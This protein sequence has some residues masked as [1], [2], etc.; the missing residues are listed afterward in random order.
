MDN[1][2]AV[3]IVVAAIGIGLGVTLWHVSRGREILNLWAQ[4][5][6]YRI[7]SSEIRWFNRG[8]FFWT[9]S[10]GQMVYYVVIQTPDGQT[11]RGYVRCGSFFWGLMKEQVEERWEG[12]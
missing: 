9:T 11:K 3:I 1:T 2:T 5:K 4:T 8:P 7:I 6:G 10:K 12:A